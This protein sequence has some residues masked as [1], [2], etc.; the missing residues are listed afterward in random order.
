MKWYDMIY[1]FDIKHVIIINNVWKGIYICY[2][3]VNY[4]NRKNERLYY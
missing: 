1:I 4:L 3:F 2:E